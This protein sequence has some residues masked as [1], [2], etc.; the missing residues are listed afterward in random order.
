MP[1]SR[2]GDTDAGKNQR[3]E[4]LN[5]LAKEKCPTR[6]TG[7]LALYKVYNTWVSDE[8]E[9]LEEMVELLPK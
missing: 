4:E 5:N 2:C 7:R 1:T 8:Y 9:A 6:D 3:P